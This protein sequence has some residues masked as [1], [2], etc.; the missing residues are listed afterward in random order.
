[1]CVLNIARGGSGN[2]PAVACTSTGEAVKY[3]PINSTD[4]HLAHSKGMML[5][6]RAAQM[7][8]LLNQEVDDSIHWAG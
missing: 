2:G 3:E 8:E 1:M 5:W 4:I 7:I 6:S